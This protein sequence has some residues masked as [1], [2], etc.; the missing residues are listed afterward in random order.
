M[1]FKYERFSVSIVGKDDADGRFRPLRTFKH[2]GK[3][4]V[5]GQAGTEYAIV[6]R[7]H[8]PER[9]E[10]VISV[11]G[12]DVVTG[13][14]A[15]VHARGYV[16]DGG[17]IL[18]L[19][20]FRVSDQNVATFTFGD[21]ESSYAAAKGD[22]SSVGVIGVAIYREEPSPQVIYK[23]VLASYK[24]ATSMYD[25]QPNNVLAP[26]TTYDTVVDGNPFVLRMS[27][28]STGTLQ[29]GTGC[30]TCA[31]NYV[32]DDTVTNHNVPPAKDLGTQFGREQESN[33]INVQFERAAQSPDEVIRLFYNSYEALVAMGI[34]VPTMP[35]SAVKARLSA[36]PFPATPR[37]SGYCEPPEGWKG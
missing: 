4:L 31:T 25:L 18:H 9:V 21:V 30:T 14:K 26:Q 16:I 13:K 12:L 23:K 27:T 17:G 29:V 37:R 32:V 24:E 35:E 10:A 5:I 8:T 1:S 6:V 22:T 3:T 15:S 2:Q 19:N 11:D 7:N 33:V 34:P 20:G 28:D 36:D